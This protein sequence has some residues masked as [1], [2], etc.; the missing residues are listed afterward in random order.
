M[1]DWK[2]PYFKMITPPA[3]FATFISYIKVNP[4]QKG[5]LAIHMSV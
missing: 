1:H 2:R 3:T 4:T 5:G